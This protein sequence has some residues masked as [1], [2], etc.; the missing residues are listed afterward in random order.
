MGDPD[1]RVLDPD[2]IR[3][4]RFV[5]AEQIPPL[6]LRLF[7]DDYGRVVRLQVFDEGEHRVIQEIAVPESPGSEPGARLPLGRVDLNFD[8]YQDLTLRHYQGANDYGELVWIFDSGR[9][10][11]VSCPELSD[12][13]YLKPDPKQWV[14]TSYYHFSASE[15]VA[16]QYKWVEGKV[17]LVREDSTRSVHTD[18]A[19]WCL[20]HVTRQRVRGCLV[21]TQR[22]CE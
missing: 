15:G 12:L 4:V 2:Y 10:R 8:G 3:T 22:S 18:D 13:P 7:G 1:D 17:V 19:H 11:F 14:V 6:R 5:V 9:R 16:T 21:E 20:E